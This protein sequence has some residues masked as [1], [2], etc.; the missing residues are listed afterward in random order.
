MSESAALAMAEAALERAE[1][2]ACS[3]E[4]IE[5]V[6]GLILA[7]VLTQI[8]S[9][10]DAS[11]YLDDLVDGQRQ[12]SG[13]GKSGAI[14]TAEQ[15]RDQTARAIKPLVEKM[16]DRRSPASI[17]TMTRLSGLVA[18]VVASEVK[19]ENGLHALAHLLA[20]SIG[21]DLARTPSVGPQEVF[22]PL[23][24]IAFTPNDGSDEAVAKADGSI[25]ISVCEACA[26]SPTIG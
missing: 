7:V 9:A 4:V 16:G 21:R 1:M 25:R 24:A 15:I 14:R 8:G 19:T 11:A 2:N 17:E 12:A 26:V 23:A 13:R 3:I 20:G 22:A 18:G 5:G 6:L 10:D